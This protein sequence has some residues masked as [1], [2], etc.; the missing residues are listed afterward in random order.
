MNMSDCSCLKNNIRQYRQEEF[1]M[2]EVLPAGHQFAHFYV[3]QEKLF[4]EFGFDP[5]DYWP[6]V[7]CLIALGVGFR[8]ISFAILCFKFRRANR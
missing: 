8:I 3:E 7:A 2:N 4:D 6:N 1:G 5:A